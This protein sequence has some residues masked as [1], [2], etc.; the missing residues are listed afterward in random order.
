MKRILAVFMLSFLLAIPLAVNAQDPTETPDPEATTEPVTVPEDDA[1]VSTEG[2]D[3]TVTGDDSTVVVEN[4]P[5][6]V[7]YWDAVESWVKSSIGILLAASVA[8]ATSVSTIKTILLAPLRDKTT[9]LDA[10]VW[11][12][13]TVYQVAVLGLVIIISA[14][15]YAADVNPFKN[16][17][18]AWVG[19]LPEWLTAV[20]TILITAYLS[21]A[22]HEFL[23]WLR[24]K[25]EVAEG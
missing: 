25:G 5:A 4:A 15:S 22:S 23:D 7:N 6:A 8:I 11:N 21:V 12:G 18:V 24:R 19:V 9:T 1:T 14:L 2:G 20:V 17:P 10:E 3:V 16:A 13:I